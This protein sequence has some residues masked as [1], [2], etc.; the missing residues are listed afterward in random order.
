MPALKVIDNIQPFIADEEQKLDKEMHKILGTYRDGAIEPY[1]APLAATCTRV[2]VR[3]GHTASITLGLGKAASTDD[4]A[5]VIAAYRGRAQDLSLPSAPAI[6]WSCA[7]RS[8]GRS[9]C[10]TAT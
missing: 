7:M 9:R 8:T 3:D 2:P 5:G 4:V 6:P 10:S 1:P